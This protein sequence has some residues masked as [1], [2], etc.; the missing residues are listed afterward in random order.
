[1]IRTETI[2]F[3]Q[4]GNSLVLKK[5][6][7]GNIKFFYKTL[8]LHSNYKIAKVQAGSAILMV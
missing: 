4:I 8:L 1:M 7:Y 5:K 2:Q 6:K 3:L